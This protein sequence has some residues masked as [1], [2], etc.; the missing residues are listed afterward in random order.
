MRQGRSVEYQ[1]VGGCLVAHQLK[2]LSGGGIAALRLISITAWEMV[3]EHLE[4]K[5]LGTGSFENL[6]RWFWWLVA[7]RL[8]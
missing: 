1:L 4:G 8:G 3:F 2:S 5:Q 6:M 7:V